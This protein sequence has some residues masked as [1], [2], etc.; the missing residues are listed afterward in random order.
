VVQAEDRVAGCA[1]EAHMV[2]G[3]IRLVAIGVPP[4]YRASVRC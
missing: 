3:M 4:G 1:G 2:V